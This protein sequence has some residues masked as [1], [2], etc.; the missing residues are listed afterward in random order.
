MTAL[1]NEGKRILHERAQALAR[2]AVKAVIEPMLEVIEFQLAN[3]RYAIETGFL[4]E[5]CPLKELTPVPCT[6]AFVRG[7]INLRG[8]I[9]AVIDLKKFFE[10]PE[11][12]L[13]D[14]HRVLVLR[15]AGLELGI[16]ADSVLGNL[17]LPVSAL[18]PELP[19][20]TGIRAEYL[21]GVTSDRLAVL[22]A[23]RILSDPKII[24]HEEVTA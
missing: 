7:M 1:R 13:Q 21:K 20:L 8:R 11:G 22:D 12:G 15:G 6:P 14:L 19:S 4:E 3:E 17:F 24:I 18:D 23:G 9:L 16:L 2:E 10:L 5:V